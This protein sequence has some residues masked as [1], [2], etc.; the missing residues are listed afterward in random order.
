[1]HGTSYLQNTDTGLL[2]NFCVTTLGSVLGSQYFS[3]RSLTQLTAKKKVAALLH[4]AENK[5]GSFLTGNEAHVQFV[6]RK[7]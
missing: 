7:S 2:E 4:G 6:V 1:M 3:Q 5:E